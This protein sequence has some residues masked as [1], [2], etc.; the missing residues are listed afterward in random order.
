MPFINAGELLSVSGKWVNHPDYGEQLKVKM[1]EKKLPQ[2]TDAIEKYL[3]SGVIKGVALLQ[4]EKLSEG[5]E[6]IR[7]ILYNLSLKLFRR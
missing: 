5:S 2:T 1:Y 6:R 4:Q 7:W 3:A